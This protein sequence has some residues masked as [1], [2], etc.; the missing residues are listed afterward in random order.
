MRGLQRVLWMLAGLLLLI[1]PT[2][3]EAAATAAV[4]GKSSD[5]FAAALAEMPSVTGATAD[6]WIYYQEYDEDSDTSMLMKKKADGTSVQEVKK[7]EL[8]IQPYNYSRFVN[9]RYA[10][11]N[12]IPAS[13]KPAFIKQLAQNPNAFIIDM[14]GD[15]VIYWI[16]TVKEGN[17]ES[18]TIKK[19]TLAG[20][21]PT[22]VTADNG[23]IDF[24]SFTIHKNTLFYTV[25]EGETYA[26]YRVGLDGKN[27]KKL[28]GDYYR[29]VNQMNKTMG[30]VP[31]YSLYQRGNIAIAQDQIVYINNDENLVRLATDGSGRRLLNQAE[32]SNP[33]VEGDWLYYS[34]ITNAAAE[35]WLSNSYFYGPIYKVKLSGGKPVPITKGH[36]NL[37]FV[38]DGW[39]Y[40]ATEW[41]E[42]DQRLIRVRTDG[43][44]AQTVL[45]G[46]VGDQELY[47]RAVFGDWLTYA[48][49][50]NGDPVGEYRIRLNGTG[51]TKLSYSTEVEAETPEEKAQAE[52]AVKQNYGKYQ[53][54]D[55]LKQAIALEEELRE[56][57]MLLGGGLLG[58]NFLE[59]GI[60]YR[61]ESTP[62]DVIPF[63]LEDWDDEVHYGFLTDFGTVS[64][65]EEA[66][67]VRVSPYEDHPVT[68]IA[69]NFREFMQLLVY[70]PTGVH[71]LDTNMTEAEYEALQEDG[72]EL[73]RSLTK[74]EKNVMRIVRERFALEP[75]GDV[76]DYL[77][78]LNKER[79]QK[80]AASTEDSLGVV[81]SGTEAASAKRLAFDF[82]EYEDGVHRADVKEFFDQA[83]TLD[84]LV[85][86]RDAQ[87]VNLWLENS[88]VIAYLQEQ[89]KA[90]GLEDEANRIA[91][92][93][94][95]VYDSEYEGEY[96]DDYNDLYESYFGS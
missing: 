62:I 81:Y 61:Y 37:A 24:A 39:V 22:V 2:L 68:I 10:D 23:K 85:F 74:Q 33:F 7:S 46:L 65:L 50:D 90:M 49:Q 54:P 91:Y 78:K 51:K 31:Y 72:A 40:Y 5:A 13:N 1:S 79:K 30:P 55:M 82:E 88:K 16:G 19:A 8:L 94:S 20:K 56:Q 64:S 96:E 66:A 4:N 12:V 80:I 87:Y 44:G 18:G 38:K 48:I 69:R 52:Q 17:Y 63:A 26:L 86:L 76:Y 11:Y 83:S 92:P 47:T 57:K 75:I 58:P 71:Y 27:K 29:S 84:K 70:E 34:T 35:D 45:S 53:V 6:G 60:G 73:E 36:S 9:Y 3:A 28:A 21:Q 77:R 95:A 89:L 15:S 32:V 41:Y 42:P 93:E 43:S 25:E 59:F 14:I 67:I